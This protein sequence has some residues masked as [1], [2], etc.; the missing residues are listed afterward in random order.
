M[1]STINETEVAFFSSQSK[2]W[3]RKCQ[4]LIEMNKVR[5]PALIKSLVNTGIISR[6]TAK[7]NKPLANLKVLE[8]GCGGGILSEALAELGA[9][10]T[11]LDVSNEMI[12][13]AIEHS[14]NNEK[15]NKNLKYV[16]EPI[17]EF[18]INNFETFDV[19]VTSETVEHVSCV[20]L[21]LENCFKCLKPD[22]LILITTINRTIR[23]WLIAIILYEYILGF[24]PKG[25]HDWYKLVLPEEL[26]TILE[27]ANFK[28]ISSGG[29][30]YCYF[31]QEFRFCT[32]TSVLYYMS[33]IKSSK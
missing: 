32:D 29:F 30:Q 19:V 31:K 5:A 17:E 15:I 27:E 13:I 21:F 18:C 2:V 12:E 7:T 3:W 26:E 28:Y 16:C 22:G 4:A 8:V 24:I 10:V 25:C 1:G 20:K 11:G 6:K 33:A 23:S 14:I 9:Q